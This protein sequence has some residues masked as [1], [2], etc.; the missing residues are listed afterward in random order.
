[1]AINYQRVNWDTTMYVNPENM[2]QM[3][4]G[5]ENACNG[6]DNLNASVDERIGDMS[7]LPHPDDDLS[8]NISAINST[9]G[10]YNGKPV[11]YKAINAGGTQGATFDTGLPTDRSF[12]C[13]VVQIEQNTIREFICGKR[14]SGAGFASNCNYVTENATTKT[15]ML[16]AATTYS[17]R[18]FFEYM[19]L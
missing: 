15:I 10:K 17:D 9:I 11:I 13:K 4:E 7:T 8:S 3:D 1:M 5:I 6:V 14:F 19:E 16:T 12:I 18:W 2:N